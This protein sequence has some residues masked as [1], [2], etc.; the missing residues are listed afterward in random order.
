M[1]NPEK[2]DKTISAIAAG[3]TQASIAFLSAVLMGWNTVAPVVRSA[4]L[5]EM[6]AFGF[7]SVYAVC[8]AP[9]CYRG[10]TYPRPRV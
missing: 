2:K 4:V 6:S 3:G 1:H 5:Q 7:S 10:L 8:A 9:F